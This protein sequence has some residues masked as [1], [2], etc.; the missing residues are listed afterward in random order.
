VIFWVEEVNELEELAGCSGNFK[1]HLNE[2]E[3]DSRGEYECVDGILV[4]IK[5]WFL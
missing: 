5:I 2:I 4:C 1:A 3:M